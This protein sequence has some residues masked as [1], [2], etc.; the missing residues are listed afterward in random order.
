MPVGDSIE[1]MR[2]QQ[3][4]EDDMLT[5]KQHPKSPQR[6]ILSRQKPQGGKN[7][8]TMMRN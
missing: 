3:I 5:P 8:E 7:D 4:G 1:I 6:I 2:D